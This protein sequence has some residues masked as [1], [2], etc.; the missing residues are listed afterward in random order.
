MHNNSSAITILGPD[1]PGL[2]D[3]CTQETL[4]FVADLTRRYRTHIEDMLARRRARQTFFDSGGLPAFL[5]ETHELRDSEWLVAPLPDDLHDRRVEITGPVD[6][7]MIINALNSGANVFMADF[8]DATSPT[9]ANLV[10]GQ[11]NLMDAVRG[12]ISHAD[13]ATG[14]SYTLDANPATLFVRPRGLHLVEKHVLVDGIPV[15]ACLFDYGIYFIQNCRELVARGK[16]PY[17][18]IPK[19]ECALEARLWN[20]IFDFSERHEGLSNGT[21]RATVLI[22][23]LPAAF[24][25]NEILYELKDHSVGLNCG[26]W[27]YIFSFIKTLH[28]DPRAILPDRS[29]ITMDKPFLRAYTD[30]LIKTCHRRGTFAMGGMAAQIPIKTDAERNRLALEQV[31]RDKEREVRAGHDGTWVAHPGLVSLARD[32]FDT[33]MSTPNQ[34]H[35]K[36]EDVLVTSVN[37]IETPDGPRT[38]AELVHDIDVGLQY[39]ESWLR[40]IGCV[41]LYDLME[42]TATAEICR[43][44]VWQWV[45]HGASVDDAPLDRNR[46]A[47]LIDARFQHLRGASVSREH[48]LAEAREIF[49]QLVFARDF[50]PFLTTVAYER[51]GSTTDVISAAA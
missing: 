3:V 46:L 30:L 2:R 21:I 47:R 18:Y 48:R 34:I 12:T 8:E 1:I 51:L 23:T 17:F 5:P 19:L 37:L 43:A 20:D 25:M 28:A 40:G 16:R 7:K 27:D 35:K 24:E 32:A 42:D 31:R 6:R 29:T 15:P 39:I 41:P 22:E 9:W 38:E 49:E 50:E 33:W 11:K 45:R 44:Q 10:S 14:K 4:T 36:R 13:V 26:R